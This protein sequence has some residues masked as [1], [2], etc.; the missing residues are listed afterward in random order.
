YTSVSNLPSNT[1]TETSYTLDGPSD[2]VSDYIVQGSNIYVYSAPYDLPAS[3]TTTGILS[4]YEF[5]GIYGGEPS[6]E[7]YSSSTSI[8]GLK[9]GTYSI[10][11]NTYFYTQS[12]RSDNQVILN[13]YKSSSMVKTPVYGSWT[14]NLVYN[15]I[16]PITLPTSGT[17]GIFSWEGTPPGPA[18][19]YVL[20]TRMRTE[21]PD[22]I[23]PSVSFG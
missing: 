11:G 18:P 8:Y 19:N 16:L 23:M 17:F 6:I 12:I 15:G 13:F 21:P 7:Y 22:N 4:D 14:G 10:G 9:G 2:A 3:S 5:A 1:I 20:W